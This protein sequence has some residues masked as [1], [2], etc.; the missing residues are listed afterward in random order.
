MFARVEVEPTF[1]DSPAFDP[2]VLQQTISE[3]LRAVLSI[4]ARV[5]RAPDDAEG[6]SGSWRA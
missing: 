3:E 6:R 1:Y 4:W 2:G 5:R